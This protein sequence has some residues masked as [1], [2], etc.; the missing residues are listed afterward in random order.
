MT[1]LARF[2]SKI[3]ATFANDAC[4]NWQGGIDDGG[5]GKFYYNS[6]PCFAHRV[7]WEL[8]RGPIPTGLWVLHKCD[9]RQCVNPEHLFLGTAQDNHDDMVSKGNR[10]SFRGQNGG[11]AHLTEADVIEIKEALLAGIPGN[12]LA[13]RYEVERNTIYHIKHGRTW[14]HI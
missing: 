3:P 5:Y 8:H 1:A 4:W 7:S 12:Q 13:L 14:S 2:M 6:R 9:N 11:N 10:A